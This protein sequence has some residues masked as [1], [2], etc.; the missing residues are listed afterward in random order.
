MQAG[1]AAGNALAAA[2]MIVNPSEILLNGTLCA[3][4]HFELAVRQTLHTRCIPESMNG[5]T[6][7]FIASDPRQDASGAAMIPFH[8]QFGMNDN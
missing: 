6:I 4:S 5:V 3:S 2:I 7:R 1:E 8:M